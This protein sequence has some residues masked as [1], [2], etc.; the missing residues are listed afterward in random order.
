MAGVGAAPVTEV[1]A[2]TGL[3]VAN[4]IVVNEYLE[5]NQTAVFGVGDVARYFDKIFEK[6]RHVEHWDN[7][8][9]QGQHWAS[10]VRRGSATFRARPVLLPRW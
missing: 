4:G 9:S 3:E 2:K 5:T 7:A 8:V 1:S 6:R 10:V